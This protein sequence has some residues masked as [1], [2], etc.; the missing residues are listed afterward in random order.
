MH[1]LAYWIMIHNCAGHWYPLESFLSKLMQI[2]PRTQHCRWR[3]AH[4]TISQCTQCIPQE[5]NPPDVVEHPASIYM[6]MQLW[7]ETFFPD[8]ISPRLGGQAVEPSSKSSPLSLSCLFD[9]FIV[10]RRDVSSSSPSSS[11]SSSWI[12]NIALCLLSA[13]AVQCLRQFKWNLFCVLLI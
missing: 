10:S 11:S 7:Q 5:S 2:Y 9:W 4:R 1:R 13:D 12:R 6:L 3:S 8:P